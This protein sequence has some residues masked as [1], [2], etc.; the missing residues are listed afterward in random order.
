MGIVVVVVGGGLK[1]FTE[2]CELG[3]QLSVAGVR[4]GIPICGEPEA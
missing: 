1:G 3:I 2:I 4:S